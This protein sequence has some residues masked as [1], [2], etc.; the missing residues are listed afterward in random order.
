VRFKRTQTVPLFPGYGQGDRTDTSAHRKTARTTQLCVTLLLTAAA[1][2]TGCR[3][4][5]LLVTPVSQRR[6]L[7]EQELARDGWVARDK[8]A[9]IDVT[10]TIA[11]KRGFELLGQGDNP[12]SL[13]FEQ[14]EAARRDKRVKGVLLRINSPG[15][16]VAASELMH[17][18]IMHF[19]KSGK[20]VVAVMM[21]MA[22]S[23]GYYIACACDEIVAQP[24]TITGSIGV[25]MQTVDLS[26]TMELV[27]VRTDAIAS[28]AMKDAGSPL[29]PMNPEERALFQHVI[30]EM[31]DRFVGVVVRG[32]PALDEAGVR[33]LAD[34]RIYTATQAL[35]QGLI[36][37][38]AT[39]RETVGNLKQRVGS[40]RI[41]LIAYARPPG[42]RP[43]YYAAPS[44]GGEINIGLVNMDQPLSPEWRIPRF[45][46]LW[47]PGLN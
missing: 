3:A 12:V 9:L 4:T 24:S 36:D 25:I 8:I 34:G 20:P 35:E 37:R 31:H 27:G 6:Q 1:A 28:G 16:T 18:E 33:R 47:A 17:D 15:G 40:E 7:V 29:R 32:R 10:G 45:L 39:L 38:I 19:R 44:L 21:D 43:N 5:S 41:R 11:N 26:G 13:L 30:G 2:T 14:L 22:T 23:G 42:Y 46:Y